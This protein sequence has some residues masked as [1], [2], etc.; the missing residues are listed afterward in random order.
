MRIVPVLVALAALAFAPGAAMAQSADEVNITLRIKDHKFDQSEV[1]VPA[2]KRII[3]TVFN[4]DPT[5]EEFES[6]S[7]KVEKVVGG[8]SKGIFRVGPFKPGKYD[9]FGDFHDD[10]A[11]GNLIAE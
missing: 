9:Y 8:K 7:M 11:K 3:I 6:R 1:K 5:P 4:D 10:T 2:G